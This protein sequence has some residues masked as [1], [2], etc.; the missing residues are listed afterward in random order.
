MSGIVWPRALGSTQKT[1]TPPPPF[2]SKKEELADFELEDSGDEDPYN[3]R[4]LLPPLAW[5]PVMVSP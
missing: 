2:N 5:L 4:L 1:P 3:P